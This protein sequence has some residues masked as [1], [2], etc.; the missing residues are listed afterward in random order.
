MSK[1][2]QPQTTPERGAR[3]DALEVFLGDWKGEGESFGGPNQD[4][5]NPRGNPTRW[6]STHSARW[7]TGKFFVIQDERAQVD[8]PFDTLSVMGW[9]DDAGR[10]FAR[11]FENHGFYRHYDVTVEGNVWTISGKTERARIEFSHDGKRQSITWEWR[12]KNV[13]LP[14]CDRVATKL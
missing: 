13:W 11:T 8:G 7:H 6:T 2:N 14:L 1:P 10:Y 4:A 5:R 12:T 9:D 3:H